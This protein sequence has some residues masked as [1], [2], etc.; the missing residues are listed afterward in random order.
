MSTIEVH[1]KDGAVKGQQLNGVS[2]WKGI[3]YAKPPVDEL[4]FAAPVPPEQ[5]EGVREAFHFGPENIQPRHNGASAEFAAGAFLESEDCLYLNVWAPEAAVT[6]NAAA[7]L[8]VMVWIHGGSFLTGAGSLPL[9]D[10]SE[11]VKRGNVIVVTINYRLGP[12]GFLHLAPLGGSFVSNA[13]LLDQIAAL[14]WVKNNIAAFGGD[15]AAV[16]IFGESA[17]SMSIAALLAMPKAK[18]L[19]S[20]AIM[21]SGASQSIAPQQ[22]DAIRAGLLQ[23][24]GIGPSELDKLRSVPAEQIF[25]A[26]EKLKE[27]AGDRFALLFQ[28]VPDEATLPQTPLE[29]IQGGAAADIPLLIG[30]N[31]NEGH[32]FIRPD[33][34]FDDN[35][36][37]SKA[38]AFMAPDIK[39]TGAAAAAYP[40]T[41]DGQAQMM[42]EAFFW[43]SSLQFATAQSEH[44]PVWMYRFDWVLPEH[45]LLN[46]A[47]HAIEI[48]FV[49]NTLEHM[50]SMGVTPD[51]SMRQLAW[52]MQDA[53]IAFAKQG[54]PK[55]ENV[56]WPAY[57][58]PE[59]STLIFNHS[60]QVIADPEA[61]KRE[62][63]EL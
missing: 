62:L 49:F 7:P 30:T 3:P 39:N 29:A 52:R 42:T 38:L 25:A 26:G 41:S 48:F 10:G 8:P 15:P 14:E 13:G 51:E 12:F 22:A 31:L 32:F 20:R 55:V 58:K 46:K 45:P 44:A 34:P 36:D 47:I 6:E 17:G 63:L 24:L 50:Q 53:W 54:K 16:T 35:L 23:G 19:Y 18:G 11:L 27:Q 56:T 59:R 33:M 43:R 40:Q 37:M 2:V 4:R 21:Q 60:I 61:Q 9:Y 28:P 5:W 1:T 57:S